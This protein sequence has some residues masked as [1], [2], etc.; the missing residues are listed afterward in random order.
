MENITELKKLYGED[1]VEWALGFL[2]ETDPRDYQDEH[3]P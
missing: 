3:Y 2:E 1:K